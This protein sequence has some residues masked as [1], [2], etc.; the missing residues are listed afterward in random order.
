MSTS[1]NDKKYISKKLVSFLNEFESRHAGHY[2]PFSYTSTFEKDGQAHFVKV[3]TKE[4]TT[5]FSLAVPSKSFLEMIQDNLLVSLIIFILLIGLT[6]VIILFVKKNKLKKQELELEREKQLAELKIKQQSANDKLSQQESEMQ[7]LQAEERSKRE[8]EEQAKRVKAQEED[9]DRQ[10]RKM[11][12]RG[13]L[14]WFEYKFGDMSGSYQIQYPKITVGR[15]NDNTWV[16]SHPTV[17]RHHFELTFK[18]YVYTI[19]DLGSSN[20]LF[21]NDYKTTEVELKHG[22]CIQIGEIILTFHI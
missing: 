8:Q 11:M 16:I 17:S 13:N 4:G 1:T 2:Y 19:R 10:I 18:D 14:P 3:V 20:G 6:I 15:D 7:R 21:V 12:E 5:G 22:D 9:D